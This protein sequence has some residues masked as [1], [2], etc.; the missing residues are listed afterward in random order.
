LTAKNRARQTV[1]ALA[2]KDPAKGVWWLWRN[3]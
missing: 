2:T 1:V 3:R